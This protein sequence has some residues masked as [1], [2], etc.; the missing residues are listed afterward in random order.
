M[1]ARAERA[2]LPDLFRYTAG[3]VERVRV[4]V[5]GREVDA[6]RRWA[7]LELT[8]GLIMAEALA[9]GG[10]STQSLCVSVARMA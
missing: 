3:A 1:I 8:R 6:E 7:N 9:G 2:A 10:A 5:E 4:A